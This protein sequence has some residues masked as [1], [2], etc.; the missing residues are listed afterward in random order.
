MKYFLEYSCNS[1]VLT[2]Y[3]QNTLAKLLIEVLCLGKDS[4]DALRLLH[5][6]AP[7]TAKAVSIGKYGPRSEKTGLWG[8]RP[9]PIQ[10]DLYTHRRKLES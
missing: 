10:T 8:F 2:C 6:K 3:F 1:S 5:Y 7:K 4:P 9:G